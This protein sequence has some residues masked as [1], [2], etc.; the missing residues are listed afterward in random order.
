MYILVEL[1][2][3]NHGNICMYKEILNIVNIFNFSRLVFPKLFY[4]MTYIHT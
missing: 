3:E 2:N 1:M 4:S